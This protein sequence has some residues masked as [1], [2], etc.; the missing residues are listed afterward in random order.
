MT[1]LTTALSD[2]LL[3]ALALGAGVWVGRVRRPGR[4]LAGFGISLVGVA[5]AVGSARYAGAEVLIPTHELMSALAGLVGMPLI[6]AGYAVAA[7]VPEGPTARTVRLAALIALGGWGAVALS[8]PVARTVTGALAMLLV[9]A[10][11]VARRSD[12]RRAAAGV[13]GAIGVMAAGLAI[14]TD[15]SWGP[16]LRV[17]AFHVALAASVG[18]LAWGLAA[19]PGPVPIPVPSP[20]RVE[21]AVQRPRKKRKRKR[22]RR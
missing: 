9:I 19:L 1:Q 12:G 4:V 16:V 14:G 21:P 6:G 20:V 17:D 5:A 10:A 2:G 7:W 11:C 3:A 15:G 8:S 13:A 22:K 18:A